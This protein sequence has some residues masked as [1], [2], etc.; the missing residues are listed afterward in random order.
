MKTVSISFRKAYLLYLFLIVFVLINF[1]QFLSGYAACR[2]LNSENCQIFRIILFGSSDYPEGET[3]SAKFS[4]LDRKGNE[5]A[6]IERS[7]PDSFLA[8]DFSTAECNGRIS[9]FPEK[10]Y[11]T[12]SVITRRHFNVRKKG[13]NL[14]PYY[15]ENRICLF[16]ITESERKNLYKAALF[17]LNP[18][19]N[20]LYF[21]SKKYTVNLSLCK[22]GV[23][24]GIYVEDGKLLLQ[25]E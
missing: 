2:K 14:V 19:S 5:I 6:V 13:T 12:D 17:A 22:N 16:G 23:Y 7:W 10:I 8:V 21:Y 20:L 24:Y 1:F 25:E 15:L 18:C 9:Y 4:L 11:G 3:V